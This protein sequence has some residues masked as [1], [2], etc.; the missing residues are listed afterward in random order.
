MNYIT[1]VRYK[2]C[3]EISE[4]LYLAKISFKSACY[5]A[6]LKFLPLFLVLRVSISKVTAVEHFFTSVQRHK[7]WHYI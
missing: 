4:R 1:R 3:Y 7:E 2:T 6:K 5:R